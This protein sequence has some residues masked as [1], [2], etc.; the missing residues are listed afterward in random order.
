MYWLYCFTIINIAEF[1]KNSEMS[2]LIILKT[3]YFRL[4]TL[5]LSIPQTMKKEIITLRR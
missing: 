4:E 5:I 2:K 3:L 1:L